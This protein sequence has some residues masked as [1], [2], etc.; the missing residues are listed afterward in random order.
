M[1]QTHRGLSLGWGSWY[2]LLELGLP[3]LN[4]S[5]LKPNDT[6][7]ILRPDIETVRVR[8]KL[9]G[10]SEPKQVRVKRLKSVNLTPMSTY[11]VIYY[12][13]KSACIEYSQFD[14][15]LDMHEDI[16]GYSRRSVFSKEGLSIDTE[17]W[18]KRISLFMFSFL[19]AFCPDI[20]AEKVD[21]D[22]YTTFSKVNCDTNDARTFDH[23]YKTYFNINKEEITQKEKH[24]KIIESGIEKILPKY[25]YMDKIVIGKG[26]PYMMNIGDGR[27]EVLRLAI[28]IYLMLTKL[29]LQN[30]DYEKTG[31]FI[32]NRLV[33]MGVDASDTS[34]YDINIKDILDKNIR[35]LKKKTDD[36]F[37]SLEPNVNMEIVIPEQTPQTGDVVADVLIEAILTNDT[38]TVK[39]GDI[40]NSARTIFLASKQ[41]PA[42]YN[43]V[44]DKITSTG[45][46]A[47]K[48]KEALNI[49]N[50]NK[51]GGNESDTDELP[52]EHIKQ[53]K[54]IVLK[55]KNTNIIK[56][57]TVDVDK[58]LASSRAGEIIKQLSRLT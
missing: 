29:K 49:L 51:I 30:V 11:D 25:M 32:G 47:K 12:M 35:H 15:T 28:N 54:S 1:A 21:E 23:I 40:I 2:I 10:E 5:M 14:N 34:A 46:L 3:P 20:L 43:A 57:K 37:G 17:S 41:V 44:I 38:D 33:E 8:T 31:E 18:E 52:V 7:S 22:G 16:H 53:I 42:L 19:N 26:V 36:T 4:I 24:K 55:V 6:L 13:T 56:L 48:Q 39:S 27:G 50:Q 9:K 58:L 45:N